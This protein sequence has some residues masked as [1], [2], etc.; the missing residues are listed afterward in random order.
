MSLF[1]KNTL[2][3]FMN[4]HLKNAIKRLYLEIEIYRPIS[5]S[6]QSV[7]FIIT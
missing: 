4:G 1:S 5:F 6:Y 2:W 7:F 3:R